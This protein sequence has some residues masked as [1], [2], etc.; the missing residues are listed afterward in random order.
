MLALSV[1]GAFVTIFDGIQTWVPGAGTWAAVRLGFDIAL[2]VL[3][4]AFGIFQEVVL[5]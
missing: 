1:V 4:V 2:N 3:L 5:G